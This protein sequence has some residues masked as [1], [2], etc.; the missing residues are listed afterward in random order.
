MRPTLHGGIYAAEAI[1]CAALFAFGATF[2]WIAI[3]A[4]ILTHLAF[5]PAAACF[6]ALGVSQSRKASVLSTR[7]FSSLLLLMACATAASLS[8]ESFEAST[9]FTALSLASLDGLIFSTR[10]LSR[11]A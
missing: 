9:A 6:R 2:H 11:P 3:A 1:A 8:M 5:I 4:G 7:V 10:E